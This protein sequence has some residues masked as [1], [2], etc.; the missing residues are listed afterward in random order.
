[1]MKKVF[2]F[3]LFLLIIISVFQFNA[4]AQYSTTADGPS[5][6]LRPTFYRM[7]HVDTVY[8]I[9]HIPNP[10]DAGIFQWDGLHPIT[11]GYTA[12]KRSNDGL[13][14]TLWLS[15]GLSRIDVRHYDENQRVVCI[16]WG[17]PPC[18][19]LQCAEEWVDFDN[20]YTKEEFEYDTANRVTKKTVTET[21]SVSG[22]E[23][24]VSVETYDFSDL[25]MT[26]KGYI[27]EDYEYE[28]DEWNRVTYLKS[29][30][31]PAGYLIPDEYME[32]D[33]KQY[34]VGDSYYTY[35]E[36][37]FSVL[38]YSKSS[39]WQLGMADRW[40]KTDNFY[41]ENGILKNVYYSY[42]GEQWEVWEK[43]ESRF[44]YA[45][46]VASGHISKENVE[47]SE[48]EAYGIHGAI[49]VSTVDNAVV[50][51]YN[52]T[53]GLVKKQSVMAGTTPIAMPQRGVY[54]VNVNN[55]SF[56]ALVR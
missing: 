44:V 53:G 17:Y 55:K 33:G 31:P 2:Y 29:L 8:Y 22:K 9:S 5:H 26:E 51:I 27:F 15:S 42:D 18:K 6:V 3:G 28:L 30:N 38:S 14:D 23:T 56:K 40:T 25:V 34:R 4:F 41:S 39:F 11:T 50:S 43:I 48:A 10:Y 35:F 19:I 54:I 52:L 13:V 36:G 20:I 37:G 21:G 49:M 32:L 24:I 45:G 7:I 47:T 16:E 1:M 12:I 46:D